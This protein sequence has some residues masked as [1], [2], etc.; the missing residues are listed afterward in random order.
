MDADADRY[1]GDDDSDGCDVRS[2]ACASDAIWNR[3]RLSSS[4]H[5]VCDSAQWHCDGS[6]K[7][8]A[9]QVTLYTEQ[10]TVQCQVRCKQSEAEYNLIRGGAVEEGPLLTDVLS[11]A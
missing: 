8:S 1:G 3:H 2:V 6:V 10:C 9:N 5:T 7:S 11:K 4:L